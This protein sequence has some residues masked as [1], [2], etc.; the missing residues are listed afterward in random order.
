MHCPGLPLCPL[1][2]LGMMQLTKRGSGSAL[3]AAAWKPLGAE[4]PPEA[5]ALPACLGFAFAL[6]PQPQKGFPL[7]H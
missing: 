7:L 4:H 5:Q 2:P 1:Q 3:R 6:D